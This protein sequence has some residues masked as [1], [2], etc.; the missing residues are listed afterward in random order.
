[1]ISHINSFLYSFLPVWVGLAIFGLWWLI[2][3]YRKIAVLRRELK[4]EQ[5][6]RL[7]FERLIS[8]KI[9]A[10]EKKNAAP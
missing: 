1:M 8:E 6:N 10:L 5:D 9:R 7:L 2:Q 4:T 3:D